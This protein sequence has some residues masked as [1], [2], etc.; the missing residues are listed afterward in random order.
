MSEIAETQSL[1]TQAT[2][3]E[4][5]TPTGATLVTEGATPPVEGEV[6][7][8]VEPAAEPVAEFVPLTVEDLVFPENFTL[9]DEI[10]SE[11]LTVVNDQELSVK[12]RANALVDLQAKLM[13]KASEASSA[14][15]DN[16]QTE[17][18]DAV[19]SDPTIGGDKMTAALADVSKLV[20]E[21][22]SK[23]LASVFDLTGAGN[24]VHVIK[25][26]HTLAGKLTEGG[27]A[28]GSPTGAPASAAQLLYG[29]S[30]KG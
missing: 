9:D 23:E 17:W 25:F 30:S 26:L 19:K 15:W 22:G 7:P 21:F 3:T 20:T 12:D 18:R 16:M 6:T 11:F 4:D 29:N 14:A 27:F 2:S 10:S 13:T 28:Q 8:P 1:V 5:G 24:N